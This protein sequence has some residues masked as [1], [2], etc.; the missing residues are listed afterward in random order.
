MAGDAVEPFHAHQI[1]AVFVAAHFVFVAVSRRGF[2][3]GAGI[4]CGKELGQLLGVRF[5]EIGHARG[6][7]RSH[8]AVAAQHLM[9]RGLGE[10]GPDARKRGRSAAFIAEIFA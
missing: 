9:Q 4:G 2:H 10:L 1:T 8:G 3:I 5:A 7:V 6:E